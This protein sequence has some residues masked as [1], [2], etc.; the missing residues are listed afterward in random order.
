[1]NIHNIVTLRYEQPACLLLRL[2]LSMYSSCSHSSLQTAVNI[3]TLTPIISISISL[4]QCVFVCKFVRNANLFYYFTLPSY[5]VLYQWTSLTMKHPLILCFLQYPLASF[6]LLR[7]QITLLNII[8]NNNIY[9][10][11]FKIKSLIWP[12]KYRFQIDIGHG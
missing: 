6:H 12:L 10:S 7:H 5:S 2:S 9:R 3:Y 1:M 4:S 8:M 11:L